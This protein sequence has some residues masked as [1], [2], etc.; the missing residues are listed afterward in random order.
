MRLLSIHQCRPGMLLAR[1]LYNEEGLVL[2]G[3]RVE[4]T[5]ALITRLAQFG[6]DYVYIQDSRTDDLVVADPVSDETRARAVKEIRSEFRKLMETSTRKKSVASGSLSKPFSNV[7]T[8]IMD[9]LGNHQD[10][11]IMLTNISVVD[12]YLYQHSLNVCIYATVLGMANG[13]SREELMTL[14]MGALLHDIGKT[15]IPF[16]ILSKPGMLTDNE[17]TEMKRH[18]ELG[19]RILKDEPNIPLISA[20]CAFQHHERINGSGYPRGIVGEEIHDYARWIGLVDSYDAMTTHRVYRKAMLPHQALE[21]LFTGSGTLFDQK[22]IELFRDRV[23]I[24]PLGITVTLNTGESGVVVDQNASFPQRPIVRILQ[25][26]DGQE[27]HAPYEIDLSKRLTV[28]ITS[29]NDVV[30]E[31]AMDTVAASS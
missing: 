6:V 5:E 2:L 23:A 3:E 29:V 13:Y 15:Q 28:I 24:Y 12:H 10:A 19:Y 31:E 16:D 4:L 9:D 8:M 26:A 22:K 21:I 14:G 7:L 11:M 17:F 30:V 20:H 27:L 25:D 1:R 18:A